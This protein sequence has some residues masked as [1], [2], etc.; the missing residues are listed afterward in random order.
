MFSMA[1]R[2]DLDNWKELG[3]PGWGFDD[4]APY[5]RKFETYNS[6]SESLAA[7]INDKYVD[8]QLRGTNGP[9]K[10]SFCDSD[11]QWQQDAWPKTCL[12]AG[13]P[14]PKDPR[15]G[16]GVGGFNQLTTVDPKTMQRSYSTREYYEPNASRPNLTVLTEALVA[17][18]E[19]EKQNSGDA[20][21]TGV[22]FIKND[23]TYT[24]KANK[25]VIISGGVINSPQILELSGIGAKAVLEKAGV[26]AIVENPGVGENLNDH[27]AT[28]L[29]Y[30]VKDEF[31]TAEVIFRNPEVAQQA[32]QAYME[33]KAGPFANPTTPVAFVPLKTIDPN[34]SDPEKHIQSLLAEYEKTHPGSDPAGRNKILGRQLLDPNEAVVQLVL[35]AVG[36]DIEH[37]DSPSKI[38]M[39][40]KPGNWASLAVCSTR[41]LSRG[42]I[43]IKSSNPEEYP[44]IDPAYFENPMDLDMI[45][46]SLLH[47]STLANYEP[48]LSKLRTDEKGDLITDPP[49]PKTLDEAREVVRK[50]TVTEYH[51]IGT[52][53]MV[54]RSKGGVVDSDCKVYGTTN[55]R[56]VDASI[57]P[58][59]VQGNI[60]SLVYAVAEKAADV[61]KGRL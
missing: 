26:Q 25:E 12:A 42:S 47:A 32:M 60:V 56:V 11:F 40:D 52:C 57:F 13:Y 15:T 20:S 22:Q 48:L 33:H 34:L 59:H 23:S 55:V 35:V 3:N 58:T 45:A 36:A 49:V 29:G 14:I 53:A 17:K 7:K 6:S 4:L 1:S 51:P 61:I 37:L 44:T 8:P 28:V 43:H 18:I 5:Y 10:I 54:P 27:T 31:P 21:A 19:L 2:Q 9:I 39:H 50:Q 38:F 46:R 16:S 24:V 41:S 30:A